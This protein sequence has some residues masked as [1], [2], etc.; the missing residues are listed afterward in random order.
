M[1]KLAEQVRLTVR[2]WPAYTQG[3]VKQEAIR[4]FM[5]RCLKLRTTPL[6]LESNSARW[7]DNHDTNRNL[8][9]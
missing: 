3:E 2:L 7:S 4:G 5:C 6:E 9:L 8:L 1:R